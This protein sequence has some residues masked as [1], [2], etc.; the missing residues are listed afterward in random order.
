MEEIKGSLKKLKIMVML[1]ILINSVIGYLLISLGCD[2]L[3]VILSKIIYFHRPIGVILAIHII[4]FFIV[5]LFFV[6]K[7]PKRKELA[8]IADSLG[9]KERFLT[10]V[11][12]IEAAQNNKE[13]TEIEKIQIADTAELAKSIDFKKL[14]KINVNKKGLIGIFIAL[15]LIIVAYYMPTPFEKKLELQR[16][17][18]V[19]VEEAAKI[20]DDAQKEINPEK[21]ENYKEKSGLLKKLKKD[22]NKAKDSQKAIEMVKDG[23]IALKEITDKEK[24]EQA[25]IASILKENQELNQLGEAIENNDKDKIQEEIEKLNDNLSDS[26]K[27]ELEKM[28][29]SLNNASEKAKGELKEILNQTGD[30][31][32]EYSK[33]NSE[34]NKEKAKASL[35]KLNDELLNQADKLTENEK[36]ND[37]VN[38]ALKNAKEKMGDTSESNSD[39]SQNQNGNKNTSDKNRGS[40]HI[41]NQNR[42]KDLKGNNSL[43]D[44]QIKSKEN[45][46]DKQGEKLKAYAQGENN[47]GISKNESISEYK[48]TAFENAEGSDMSNADKEAVK[49][50]FS[51]LN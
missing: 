34:E 4:S 9:F 23:E 50:Y 15:I 16:K 3:F 7:M 11:E 49:K 36:E 41:E 2:L 25:D 51:D 18:I 30:N 22:I 39:N 14:Y 12:I 43:E 8:K 33:D 31:V 19:K 29:E 13:L 27:E 40:G 24:A 17:E 45:E 5:P 35:D 20:I 10:A 47:K 48:K 44:F 28:A 26:S 38:A 42:D 37:G 6:L 46:T 32:K 1:K 21:I